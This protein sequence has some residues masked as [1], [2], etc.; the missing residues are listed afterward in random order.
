MPIKATFFKNAPAFR[1]WLEKYAATEKE[2]LVGFYKVGTGKPS[3]S[4]PES[5]DQALCFGWIDGIRK[6]IDPE[7]YSIRF[8]PRKPDSTWSAINIRK[9]AE[10]TEKE[11]MTEAGL[12]AFQLR[13]PEK[14][15][16]YSFESDYKELSADL[17]VIFKSN[18]AAWNFFMAQAPYYRKMIHHWILSAKQEKTRL[19]RLEKLIQTSAQQIRI[20]F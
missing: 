11:L 12:T 6:S 3:I 14:S 16:I 15:G 9:V 10:L 2:L 18:P 1:K 13:K 17:V 8:T 4:W 7:S 20:Q 5:V 19:S